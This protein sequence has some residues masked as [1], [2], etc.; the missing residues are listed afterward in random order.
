MRYEEF[1]ARVRER[2]E[3]GSPDEARE[4]TRAVLEVLAQRITPDEVADLA[5]QMPGDLGPMLTD[6]GVPRA[7]GFGIEEFH[8]RVAERTGARPRTAVWDASAVL[9]TVADAVSG[10]EVD[11]VLSQ[12]PSSYAPLFGRPDLAD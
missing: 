5:S 3:Y 4:V 2:G 9:T 8:Q 7:E 10:G 1:L 11:Q 6:S 12:L